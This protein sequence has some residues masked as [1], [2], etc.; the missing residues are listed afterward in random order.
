MGEHLVIWEATST[1]INIYYAFVFVSFLVMLARYKGKSFELFLI[2]MFYSGLFS[3]ASLGIFNIYKLIMPALSILWLIKTRAILSNKVTNSVLLSFLFFAIVFVGISY[4]NEDYTRL[5]FSQLSRY[6]NILFFFLLFSR[7]RDSQ[8]FKDRTVVLITDIL[9]VQIVLSIIKV[10]IMGPK[11][12]LVGSITSQGGAI[13]TTIPILG[14][15][16]YWLKKKGRF[17]L[18]DWLFVFG[19]IF[20]GFA[21]A[22]RALWF[23]M[24]VVITAIFYYV[25]QRKILLKN[26]VLVIPIVLVIFYVGVRLN[27]S[28]NKENKVWGSFDLDYTM[29]YLMN[30]NFGGQDVDAS[31]T[32]R[33]GATILIVNNL[34]S[35]PFS[36]QN[37]FG[38]GLRFV[39]NTSYEEFDNM[40]YGINTKG[41]A[42]GIIRDW[43]SHGLIGIIAFLIFVIS[44]IQKTKNRRLRTVLII[45]FI[46]D[47]FLY[48]GS[49]LRD[50]SQAF[51][52][53]Y[54]VMFA[55]PNL[56]YFKKVIPIKTDTM[57]EVIA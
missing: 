45:V 22:K 35:E 32:G 23:I 40:D 44:L 13:A 50:Q 47:Y 6:F 1:Q 7:F 11:E 26:L 48:T 43:I 20:I 4:R 52:F 42:T 56:S 46:W 3:Y 36:S 12:S 24:P 17:V 49:L 10:F 19:L 14:F 21:G 27:W 29:S 33:G 9:A 34:I 41:S 51:L 53:L 55:E 5:I 39:S 30:Y 16:F 28:L 37:L 25:A 18:H 2:L 15:I 57:K 8:Q 38:D 31:G 54:L